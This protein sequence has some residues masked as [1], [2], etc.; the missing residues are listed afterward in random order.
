M[1]TIVSAWL[2]HETLIKMIEDAVGGVRVTVSKPVYQ[3]LY[4]TDVWVTKDPPYR[5]GENGL[6]KWRHPRGP[7]WRRVVRTCSIN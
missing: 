3:R 7:E 1:C 4:C 5:G 2:G 6:P